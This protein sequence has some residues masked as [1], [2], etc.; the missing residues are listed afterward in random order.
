[1]LLKEYLTLN[2]I[3]VCQFSRYTDISL[4]TLHNIVRGRKD[5]R[6]S[7]AMTIEK[8]T[9]GKVTCQ[10]LAGHI[11][12]IKRYETQRASKGKAKTHGLTVAQVRPQRVSEF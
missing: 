11:L 2:K 10:D 4:P 9:H 7:T 8:A 1:M 3:S 12:H 5:I 6:L